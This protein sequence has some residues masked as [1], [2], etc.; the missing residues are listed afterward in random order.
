[1]N[2]HRS[3]AAMVLCREEDACWKGEGGVSQISTAQ[4]TRLEKARDRVNKSGKL[5]T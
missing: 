3:I 2:Q 1:M 5:L 4:T